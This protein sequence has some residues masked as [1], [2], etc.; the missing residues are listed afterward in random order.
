MKKHKLL[1]GEMQYYKDIHSKLIHKLSKISKLFI[2]LG[3]S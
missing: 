1:D 3:T 2:Y